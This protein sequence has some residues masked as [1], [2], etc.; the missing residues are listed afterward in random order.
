[1]EL[2]YLNLDG[3]NDLVKMLNI[4]MKSIYVIIKI[5]YIRR[6]KQFG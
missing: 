2:I 4:L 1:M 5:E 6:R 3:K